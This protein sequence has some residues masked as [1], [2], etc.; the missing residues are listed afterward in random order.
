MSKRLLTR[1]SR[2]PPET[3]G[4]VSERGQ[5]LLVSPG[6]QTIAEHGWA[7]DQISSAPMHQMLNE[8][9]GKVSG[10]VVVR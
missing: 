4:T 8:L 6:T 2:G 1:T 9:I 3:G 10:L 7:R 5:C